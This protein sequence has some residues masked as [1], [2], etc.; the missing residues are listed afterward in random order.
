MAAPHTVAL[1]V[2]TQSSPGQQSQATLV[3][4]CSQEGGRNA[5]ELLRDALAASGG[6]GGGSATLAQGLVSPEGL[7]LTLDTLESSL[8]GQAEIAKQPQT[9]F[10]P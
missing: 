1:L 10:A 3:I 2:S 6:R 5:G 8:R 4:A 7:E 9:G